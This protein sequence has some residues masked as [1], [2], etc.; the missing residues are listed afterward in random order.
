MGLAMES[1]V[2]PR[3]SVTAGDAAFDTVLLGDGAPTVVFVNGLGSPLEEWAL[4][5]P[6]IARH[7][8]VL[9]Y[10]RR[11]PPP[12]GPLPT[13]DAARLAADL[14]QLL[15]AVGVSGPLVLVGHSWGGALIRRYAVEHPDDVA[16]LV[17][18]DASH[19]NI[20]AMVREPGRATRALYA[21]STLALRFGPFRRRLLG[22]LGFDRLARAELTAVNSLAWRDY[23]RGSRA[24]YAGV[25]PSLRELGEIAPKFPRVPTRILLGAGRPGLT[26]KLARKQLAS[27]RN[28]WEQAADGTGVTVQ[29]VPDSGH[30]IS[31]DQPQAVIDAIEDVLSQ[32]R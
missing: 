9:C 26:A 1:G 27:V 18:V 4:V 15:T 20:A 11:T 2:L 16:G 3:Q 7:C 17:F 10:D 8:R 13:H 22:M 32:V 30:Y 31:L 5:A 6:A 29:S 23:G 14:H 28:A 21:T 12:D 25:A 24:E 19:E